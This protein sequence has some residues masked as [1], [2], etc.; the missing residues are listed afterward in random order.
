MTA[1]SLNGA[2][3]RSPTILSGAI[4]SVGELTGFF[5]HRVDHVL[6]EVA[7]E[8]SASARAKPAPCL[9]AKAMSETGAR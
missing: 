3:C 6:V 1:P 2:P 4:T 5:Q 8:P 7:V 9:S